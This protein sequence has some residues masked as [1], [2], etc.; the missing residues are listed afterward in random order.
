MDLKTRRERQDK[1]EIILRELS[2]TPFDPDQP[3]ERL[4]QIISEMEVIYDD[5]F[6]HSYSKIFPIVSE[7]LK[8]ESSAEQIT[9]L[10]NLTKIT[11]IL[12]SEEEDTESRENFK[13]QIYKL[14]DHVNLEVARL[15]Y[16]TAGPESRINAVAKQAKEFETNIGGIGAEIKQINESL[17]NVDEKTSSIQ[18]Q[19]VS[20]LAIFAAIIIAFSGGISFITSAL[21][22]MRTCDT[23]QVVM[24][25]SV[26]ALAVANSIFLLMYYVGKITE[27]NLKG[28]YI[29]LL[30]LFLASL[31]FIYRLSL[32]A[33]AHLNTVLQ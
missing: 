8:K 4:Y 2:V 13:R 33:Y 29:V 11:E 25:I 26:S 12:E 32:W 24:V 20:I 21:S 28:R 16:I 9:I 19:F 18:T 14:W 5:D 7:A 30:N 15:A 31:P 10:S 1:L 3:N 23:Q 6:R 27:R 22:A 17:Q